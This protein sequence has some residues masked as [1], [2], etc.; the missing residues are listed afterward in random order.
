MEK[1]IAVD[2][3]GTLNNFDEVLENI[4][5]EYGAKEWDFSEE[6]FNKYLS[7]IKAHDRPNHNDYDFGML[8]KYIHLKCYEL[9]KARSDAIKFMQWLKQN[10]WKII[11]LTAR[12][13]R[14]S[15]ETTKEFLYNNKIP[16]D[17]I[18]H[19]VSVC[20]IAFCDL[21]EINYLI[22]DDADAITDNSN[23]SRRM[24]IFYPIMEKHKN[25][26]DIKAKGFKN[27]NEVKA[28]IA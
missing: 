17:Y 27:F 13:L 18:F 14:L 8:Y 22:D 12:D 21:W 3:D 23:I 16:F 24:N 19:A 9:T 28:W 7:L 10:G 20:K 6:A 1:V 15:L 4:N 2:I 11:I 5:I 25:L 26:P